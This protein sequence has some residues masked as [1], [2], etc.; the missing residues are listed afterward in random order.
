M[1]AC[2]LDR[3]GVIIKDVNY[4]KYIKDIKFNEGIFNGLK[5]LT[6]LGYKLFI[7]T[8]QSAVG[9]GLLTEKKLFKIHDY[10]QKKLKKKNIE[11]KKI[12]YC[13][14]HPMAKIKKY[15]RNCKMRKP[16]PGMIKK[17]FKIYNIKPKNSILFGD[18]K[19]DIL[20]G[21]RAKIKK[22]FLY[23]DIISFE[24][25]INRLLIDKKI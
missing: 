8:N 13:P 6:Q 25:F 7:I 2:F 24:L 23:N 20:A 16:K 11:I 15:Q 18:K 10:I 19:T 3:D 22:N 5:I 4:L 14:C 12:L 1:K 9:R 21:K 17:I